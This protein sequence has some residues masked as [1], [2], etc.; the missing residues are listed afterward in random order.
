MFS[1]S[2]AI[3]PANSHSTDSST[4]THHHHLRIVSYH[5]GLVQQASY[6]STYQVDSESPYPQGSKKKVYDKTGKCRPRTPVFQGFVNLI[7]SILE[8][9]SGQRLATS[10]S[11]GQHNTHAPRGFEPTN[12]VL[13]LHRD[14]L[15]LTLPNISGTRGQLSRN[16]VGLDGRVGGGSNQGCTWRFLSS[17]WGSLSLHCNGYGGA[18]SPGRRRPG[19][20]IEFHLVPSLIICGAV[21]SI[22][23]KPSWHRCTNT[24]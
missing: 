12:P 23:H 8:G 22:P 18:P 15:I 16:S 3:S 10:V 5:P 21:T 6:W 4:L 2:T 7:T 9:S 24:T 14:R 1:R 20:K 11:T 19:R 13:E 17:L